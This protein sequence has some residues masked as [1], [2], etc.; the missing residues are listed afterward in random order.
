MGT[1]VF[2]PRWLV[3]QPIA[4]KEAQSLDVGESPPCI[5]EEVAAPQ[6]EA[7]ASSSAPPTKQK[8]ARPHFGLR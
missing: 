1:A 3:G 5:S 7:L 6:D 4:L 2:Q 8:P